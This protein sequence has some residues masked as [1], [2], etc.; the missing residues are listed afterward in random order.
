MTGIYSYDGPQKLFEKLVRDF[1]AFCR[2]PS[3]DG[4]FTLVFPLYHLRDWICPG[5][6]HSYSK[7]HR[8]LWTNEEALHDELFQMQEYLIV[9]EMCNNARHFSDSS[10]GLSARTSRLEGFRA[11]LGRCGDSLGVT[12]FLVDGV[13]VRNIF[14]PVY[15][16]YFKYFQ[17]QATLP[18]DGLRLP[19]KVGAGCQH[20]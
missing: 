6:H 20:E 1:T 4:I 15:S 17:A 16:V 10:Y 19:V 2:S 8:S 5:G 9:R 18:P 14:W 13:E 12:H 7:K 11:G 3:E